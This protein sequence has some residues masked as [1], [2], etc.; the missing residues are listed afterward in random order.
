MSTG[1]VL[2][3]CGSHKCKNT[4]EAQSNDKQEV[5]VIRRRQKI[6]RALNPESGY[7]RFFGNFI[8]SNALI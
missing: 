1:K 4:T 7:E 5:L 2:Y 6:V 3:E 8:L